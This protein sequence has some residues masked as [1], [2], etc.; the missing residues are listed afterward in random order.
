[1]MVGLF[2]IASCTVVAPRSATM[3]RPEAGRG[4]AHRATASIRSVGSGP[5]SA[6]SSR[7]ASVVCLSCCRAE[8]VHR[9][10]ARQALMEARRSRPG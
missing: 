3:P 2:N 1:M 6:L 8:F 10:V 9:C 5:R 4:A 7:L